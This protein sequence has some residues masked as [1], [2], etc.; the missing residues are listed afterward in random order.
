MYIIFIY[1]RERE[2]CYEELAHVIVQAEKFQAK[3]CSANWKFWRAD[4]IR[5]DSKASRLETQEGPM[6]PFEPKGKKR[7][8]F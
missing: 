7:M 2:I 6:F 3:I 4:D 8:L 5:S 1:E